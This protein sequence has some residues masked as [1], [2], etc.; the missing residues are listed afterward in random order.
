MDTLPDDLVRYLFELTD[1]STYACSAI[2]SKRFRKILSKKKIDTAKKVSILYQSARDGNYNLMMLYTTFNSPYD[3]NIALAA[4]I[5]GNEQVVNY[6]LYSDHDYIFPLFEGAIQGCNK[7]LI[8][9]CINRCPNIITTVISRVLIFS[10][11]LVFH[12]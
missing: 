8:F 2:V 9:A 10:V 7:N 3:R 12:T 1:K 6:F 4:G 5:S 11:Q